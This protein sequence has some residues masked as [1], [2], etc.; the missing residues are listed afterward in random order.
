MKTIKVKTI[1]SEFLLDPSLSRTKKLEQFDEEVT[2]FLSTIDANKIYQINY[3]NSSSAP[4]YNYGKAPN[5][6]VM[7]VIT[8]YVE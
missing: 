3:L 7:A 1:K 6:V 2:K 8:Y 4:D 5:S